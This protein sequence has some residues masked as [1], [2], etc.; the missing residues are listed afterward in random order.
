M[1]KVKSLLLAV[2]L[3]VTSAFAAF[4]EKDITLIVPWSAGG[5]TD[6]I[7][8]ALVKNAKKHI[9]VNV[10]VINK[11]GGQGVV[12]MSAAK[13]ARPDGYSVGMITFGLSTYKLM[14]LSGLNYKDFK[15][16]QLLN[17]SAP[18]LSVKDGSKLTSIA[19][20]IKEAKANPG[21]VTIG[22]TGAGVA[23]HLSAA[24]LGLKQGVEFNFIPFDG[25][26]P[27]RAAL[28]G[29][30]IDLAATG[31]DEMKQ[32][33]EAG[34]VKIIATDAS[35]RHPLFPNVPTLE[36]EGYSKSAPILDWRGLALPKNVPADRAEVLAAGFKK[37]FDDPEFV[38]FT[39]KVGLNLVY[40]DAKGFDKFLGDMENILKPTLDAVGLLKK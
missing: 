31:I 30:H 34:Q 21:K 12:G 35:T 14:G 1:K 40:E 24:A 33:K 38:E 25:G 37:M 16:L 18:A 29:G 4:P 32:L 19:E 17:Q 27:T 39:K 6:T 36:E 3:S 26:A 13:R 9:G 22:H 10:N 23:W 28:L 2:S 5:G 11:T 8:R 15:L 20:V 7:A